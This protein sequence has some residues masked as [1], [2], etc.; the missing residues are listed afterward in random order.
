MELLHLFR[1]QVIQV[2]MDLKF[3]VRREDAAKLWD[4]I[5]EAGKEDGLKPCGLRCT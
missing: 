1:V 2:K 4:E 5:L 3:T